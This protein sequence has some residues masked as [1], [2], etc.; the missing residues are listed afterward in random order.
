MP[1]YIRMLNEDQLPDGPRREFVAKLYEYYE[2]AEFPS[3][4]V[5]SDRCSELT[6]RDDRLR[7]SASRETVRR[8]LTGSSVREGVPLWESV[9]VV[10]RALCDLAGQDPDASYQWTNGYEA[11]TI[12]FLDELRDAWKQALKAPPVKPQQLGGWGGPVG[13]PPF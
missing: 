3:L 2:R 7:G 1:R 5:I 11:E 6:E 12:K 8:M 4:Q 13:E 9:E 10:Y